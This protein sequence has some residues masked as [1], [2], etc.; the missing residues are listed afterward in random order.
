LV[1]T[2]DIVSTIVTQR[3]EIHSIVDDQTKIQIP[4]PAPLPVFSPKVMENLQ[5]SKL[6]LL[7]QKIMFVWLFL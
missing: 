7:F 3:L 1:E 5:S 6:K 2:D 4:F